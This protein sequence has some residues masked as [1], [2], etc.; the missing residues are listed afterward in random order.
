M[1][2]GTLITGLIGV[3]MA[4]A[5][6]LLAR[7]RMRDTEALRA[8]YA[9]ELAN[10]SYVPVPAELAMS[11]G[12]RIRRR[13]LLVLSYSAPLGVISLFWVAVQ[14][15]SNFASRTVD[16]PLVFALPLLVP[17]SVGSI[18]IA[19][20][21]VRARRGEIERALADGAQVQP[22]APARSRDPRLWLA[23]L[24]AFVPLAVVAAVVTR[25]IDDPQLRGQLAWLAG[26]A[27]ISIGG[28]VAAE[29]AQSSI[30]AGPRIGGAPAELAID[31]VFADLLALDVAQASA[32]LTIVSLLVALI[33]VGEPIDH[34]SLLAKAPFFCVMAVCLL[35]LVVAVPAGQLPGGAARVGAISESKRETS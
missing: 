16:G 8:R 30:L 26:S 23:R 32:A 11:V 21:L 20:A 9:T 35:R 12:G 25:L 22:H 15:F 19:V 4:V 31:G 27:V 33:A 34:G 18:L 6:W 28:L 5:A 13:K 1:I 17:Y 7:S 3:V 24:V 10:W 29:A 2:A 14:G